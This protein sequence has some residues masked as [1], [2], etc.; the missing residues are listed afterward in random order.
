MNGNEGEGEDVKMQKRKEALVY[1]SGYLPGVSPEKSPVLSLEPVQFPNPTDGGDS[2]KDVCGGGCGFAMAISECGKLITWG[3]ADDEG[4]SYLIAGKHGEIPGAFPLPTE[5]SLVKAAAGWA[6]CVSVTE[7]GEVYTWGWKE[8]VPSGKVFHD[9]AFVGSLQNDATTTGKQCSLPADQVTSLSQGL[10]LT[11]DTVSHLD[12]KRAGEEIAKRRKTSSAKLEPESST[13]SDELFMASPCLVN[14]GP[15][16]RITTVA[17]GGRHTLALSDMGQVWGWGYGGE[18]QLGLGSR[19]KMVSSPHLIPCIDPS[20]SGKDRFCA[21]SQGS[22]FPGSYVKEIAC[23]GRHSA[24]ITDA[25]ALLTFGWGLY[26]QCGQG[27]T[28]DQ[29]KV[30]RVDSLSDTR[31]KNVAAGLWHTL[32]ITVDG[33]VY[34]FGG[35]QFGQLGTGAEEAE[36]LPRLL[37]SSSLENKHA[38]VVSCGARHSTILTEDG[39]LFSWGW[40]KYGQLGLGDTVDRNIPCQV[41]I[42]GCLPKDIACGWWHTLLLAERPI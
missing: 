1:M 24:V 8:C 21:V 2:W 32:C 6:H 38:K 33:R 16:V 34:A 17:A 35:N 5:V 3:S 18:G 12:S 27:S 14:I 15:G 23:G 20:V 30:T 36:T 9:S 29:L 19:M 10:N 11:C 31:V 41:S 26:G 28:K 25:G 42:D 7:T 22:K 40:N 37:D 4:Q 39:Q 13:A